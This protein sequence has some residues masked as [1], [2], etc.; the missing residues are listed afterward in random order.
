MSRRLVGVLL[1]LTCASPAAAQKDKDPFARRPSTASAGLDSLVVAVSAQST[2]RG[3]LFGTGGLRGFADFMLAGRPVTAIGDWGLSGHLAGTIVA[4]ERPRGPK[5]H[6]DG[7]LRVSRYFD[8]DDRAV[9][10]VTEV[11]A[12]DVMDGVEIGV[13][14]TGVEWDWGLEEVNP[15]FGGGLYRDLEG[16]DGVR[17]QLDFV[18]GFGIQNVAPWGFR[19][20]G[21]WIEAAGSWSDYRLRE[22]TDPDE[23]AWRAGVGLALDRGHWA[24]SLRLVA[25]DP[26][27]AGIG[28]DSELAVRFWPDAA[29]LDWSGTGLARGRQLVRGP[30]N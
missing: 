28:A 19:D 20:V 3:F 10:V 9:S 27:D 17:A 16:F 2:W 5:G 30:A 4:N 6:V 24:M 1:I 21:G 12:S 22:G 29:P 26:H 13:E 18:L 14:V 11:Y 25:R 23:L 7:G 8:G 15:Q